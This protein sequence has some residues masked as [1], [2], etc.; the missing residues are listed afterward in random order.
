MRDEGLG[1]RVQSFVNE[2]GLSGVVTEL[3]GAADQGTKHVGE[4]K[5][6]RSTEREVKKWR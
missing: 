3:A 1:C 5:R 6:R 2:L 4:E